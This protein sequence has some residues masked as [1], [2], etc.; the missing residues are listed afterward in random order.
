MWYEDFAR[1]YLSAALLFL[2]LL[3]LH[4]EASQADNRVT[5]SNTALPVDTDGRPLITGETSVLK[6]G[7]Y[8]YYYVN[9][10]GDCAPVDCCD[11]PGGCA[12]CCYVPSSAAYPDACV[13][14]SNHSV[15]VYQTK[16][17]QRW[18][19]IGL[20]KAKS[21]ARHRVPSHLIYNEAT[22]RFVMWYEDR[23]R[24]ASSGYCGHV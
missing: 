22:K 6:A 7:D 24:D 11:S 4:G 21:T 3:P 13:F 16:D 1:R 15:I 12:S 9:N 10:W 8:Y 18:E 19:R 2:L 17:F 23:A 5:L 14:V 20:R